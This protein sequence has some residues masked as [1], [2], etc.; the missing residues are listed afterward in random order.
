MEHLYWTHTEGDD[1]LNRVSIENLQRIIELVTGLKVVKQEVDFDAER[2]RGN[3]ERYADHIIVRVRASLSPLWKRFTVVK[4]LCHALLDDPSEFSPDGLKTIHDLVGFRG[5][6][7]DQVSG[8]T[9]SERIAEIMALEVIYPLENRRRDA[10]EIKAKS[11]SIIDVAE[12]RG[13]P[14]YWV[15]LATDDDYIANSEKLWDLIAPLDA[16]FKAEPSSPWKA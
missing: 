6:T 5:F 15:G 11:T 12:R 8:E 9:Q 10:A 14:P 1:A 13:V 3:Y 16:K 2:L 4:E 7:I